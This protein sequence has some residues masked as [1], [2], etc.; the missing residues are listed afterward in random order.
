[1]TTSSQTE[2]PPSSILDI[3]P[4]WLS[5]TESHDA[6]S[7][8]THLIQTDDL[9]IKGHAAQIVRGAEEGA[10]LVALGVDGD[11]DEVHFQTSAGRG[12]QL[13]LLT[14]A[15]NAITTARAAARHVS[16]EGAQ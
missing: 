4:M 8:N 13:D 5:I 6:T 11:H 9:Q 12:N 14:N 15:L 10:V 7:T 16:G 1:M 2:Q 3:T